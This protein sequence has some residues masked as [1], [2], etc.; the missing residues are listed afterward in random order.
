MEWLTTSFWVLHLVATAAIL[1][2]WLLSFLRAKLGVTVMAWA[3]RSQ[4]VIGLI[5]VNLTFAGGLNYAKVMVKLALAVVTVGLIEVTNAKLKRDE[6]SVVLPAVAV[7]LTALIA[8][9]SFL[10]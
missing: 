6:H 7:V 1:G 3:A 4:I 5:L 2:G 9:A 10:W 8:V